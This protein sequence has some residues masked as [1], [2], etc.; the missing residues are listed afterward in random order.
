MIS[1]AEILKLE[2]KIWNHLT[3]PFNSVKMAEFDFL[4]FNFLGPLLLVYAS[5]R[6]QTGL[7]LKF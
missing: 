3:F 4:K 6:N 1:I 2:N 7:E 5:E